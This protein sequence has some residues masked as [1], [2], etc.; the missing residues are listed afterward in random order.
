MQELIEREIPLPGV[1]VLIGVSQWIGPQE[2]VCPPGSYVVCQRLSDD[3]SPLK[4]RTDGAGVHEVYPQVRSLGFMPSARAITMY[5]LERPFRTLN[6]FFDKQYFETATELD[7]DAWYQRTGSFMMLS[8]RNVESC[9]Q[10]IHRELLQPDFGSE[11][12]IEAASTMI[13]IEMARLARQHGSGARTGDA[14][15]RGGQGLAP[16]Q[17]RRIRERLSAAPQHG[18][19]RIHDLAEICGISRGHLMRMFK[20][21]T[22]Q[23]L[24]R[25]I[26]R[27]RLHEAQ[28][29]LVAGQFSIKEIAA[30]LGF[31]ST[32]HFT[33]AFRNSEA[34]PPSEFR[35]RVK[36]GQLQAPSQ[37]SPDWLAKLPEDSRLH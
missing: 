7:A 5:P 8:N 36:A 21:S 33:T 30:T 16:W 35:S 17:M 14:P 24:H 3:H 4:L 1:C 25:Y 29:M 11:P 37:A 9:M 20:V 18:Y 15:V 13:A 6:C 31:C 28:R 2:W 26:M 27:Q 23:P 32:A 10:T 19:P 22:G 12:L 34:M